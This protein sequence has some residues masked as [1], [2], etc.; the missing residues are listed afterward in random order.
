ML[1][2]IVSGEIMLK[3]LRH[4][5]DPGTCSNGQ[6]RLIDGLVDQEGRLE[7]CVGGVWGGICGSLFGQSDAY[8]ACKELG[9]TGPSMFT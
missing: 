4:N 3:A 7:V 8:I 1:A 2:V 5:V 9:Y 6:L